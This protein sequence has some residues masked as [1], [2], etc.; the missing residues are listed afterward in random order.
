M[1]LHILYGR[2]FIGFSFLLCF[3]L[4][5]LAGGPVKEGEDYD[6]KPLP[7]AFNLFSAELSAGWGVFQGDVALY[8]RLP[9]PDD[10]KK[11]TDF[12][13]AASISREIKYGLGVTL[14]YT[15]GNL[16]GERGQLFDQKSHYIFEAQF[17]DLSINLTYDITRA[18][19]KK[20]KRFILIGQVGIGQTSFRSQLIQINSGLRKGY[21]GYKPLATTDGQLLLDKDDPVTS[22]I[23]PVG[24]SVMYRLNY[25]TDMF[26]LVNMRNTNTDQVDS[27]VRNWSS[28][29]KYTYIGL[30]LRFNFN[31]TKSDHGIVKKEKKEKK[32]KKATVSVDGSSSGTASNS[33]S[34]GGSKLAGLFKRNKKQSK[35]NNSG[36][37]DEL[38]ELRLKLFET[39]LKLFEMQYLLEK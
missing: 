6:D 37:G 11:S 36:G 2:K 16:K 9:K 39:Q 12:A 24:F 18:L 14:Q 35:S 22:I 30:G 27:W 15:Q 5:V 7:G 28:H 34:G 25:K 19:L 29:D 31:R 17:L 3:W 13:W 23:V 38:L 32:G 33:S 10:W 21:A 26:C 1:N 4:P 8:D 20:Q